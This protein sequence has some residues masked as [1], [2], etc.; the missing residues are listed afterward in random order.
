MKMTIISHAI[1]AYVALAQP[2]NSTDK[3]DG[4][5]CFDGTC[6][7]CTEVCKDKPT[8]A[9]CYTCCTENC[10]AKSAAAITHCQDKCDGLARTRAGYY[11][12]MG[13]LESLMAMAGLTWVGPLEMAALEWWYW[14]YPDTAVNRAA[15][16]YAG[17][18]L[19]TDLPDGAADQILTMMAWG[20]EDMRDWRIRLSSIHAV[21]D[22]GLV[23]EF[24]G[25]LLGRALHDPS[26]D[27]RIAA[28]VALGWIA[29][30]GNE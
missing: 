4:I 12:E 27:V 3:T 17:S 16:V 11:G 8:T 20:V 2:L 13:T 30:E 5:A 9:S 23:G 7:G 15:V 18:F 26:V 22:A 19:G 28:A 29:E 10:A 21:V 25:L 1:L 24:E 6:T 14:G